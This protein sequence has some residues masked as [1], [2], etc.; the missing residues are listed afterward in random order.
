MS[1]EERQ[2]VFGGQKKD[3]SG[4]LDCADT[5]FVTD[6]E[7]VTNLSKSFGVTEDDAKFLL[8]ET[9]D[10][11]RHLVARN[12]FVNIRGFGTFHLVVRKRMKVY[13]AFKGIECTIPM[14]YMIRFR[15]SGIFKTAVNMRVKRNMV[16]ARD[17]GENEL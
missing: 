4:H 9:L 5:R 16:A 11:I 12:G 3:K 13:N 1:K 8:Y 2:G 17:I 14:R 15:P 6:P 7:L 10:N